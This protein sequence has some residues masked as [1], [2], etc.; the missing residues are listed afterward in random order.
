[1][2]DTEHSSPQAT[3]IGGDMIT[4]DSKHKEATLL[5][6]V[7]KAY[8]TLSVINRI[9]CQRMGARWGQGSLDG[10]TSLIVKPMLA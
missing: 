7:G 3:P 6:C 10:D 9:A 2:S 5:D 1:M 4:G 8:L